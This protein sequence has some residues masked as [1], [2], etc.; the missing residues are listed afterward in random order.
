MYH[1]TY[2]RPGTGVHHDARASVG[3][4]DAFRDSFSR[5][6]ADTTWLCV[7]TS[8]EVAVRT[9]SFAFCGIDV[10]SQC[11]PLMN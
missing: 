2:R 7:P 1:G 5:R 4:A 3:T 8:R 9:L 11:L 10:A 6:F